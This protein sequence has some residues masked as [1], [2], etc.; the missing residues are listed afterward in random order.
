MAFLKS[1]VITMM[2]L[3]HSFFSGVLGYSGL[4]VVGELCFHDAKQTW[5]R[6]PIF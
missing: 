1:S 3:Y 6:L 2:I 5:F 4:I